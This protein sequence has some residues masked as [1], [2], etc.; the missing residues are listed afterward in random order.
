M[1][2][3]YTFK[4][5]PELK[6]LFKGWNDGA[7]IPF[8]D[9][10][11][12]QLMPIANTEIL[13]FAD[14]VLLNTL[15][16]EVI[17]DRLPEASLVLDSNAQG[18]FIRLNANDDYRLTRAELHLKT[19]EETIETV[20]LGITGGIL[21]AEFFMTKEEIALLKELE[22]IV[23]DNLHSVKKKIDLS[24]YQQEEKNESDLLNAAGNEINAL[25]EEQ[26][27]LSNARVANS[28]KKKPSPEDR[29]KQAEQIEKV[30]EQLVKKDSVQYDR[31]KELSEKLNELIEKLDKNIPES[32]K[33]MTEKQMEETLAKLE[34]EW[35][36]LKAIE[37]LKQLDKA[38]EEKRA[39]SEENIN[40]IQESKEGLEKVLGQEE[41]EKL[42]WNRFDSLKANN[43]QLAKEQ[44]ANENE[45]EQKQEAEEQNKQGEQ[46]QQKEP[47]DKNTDKQQD[48]IKQQMKED[49]DAL[50]QQLSELSTTMMMDAM[51]KNVE[52]IRRLE[53]RS[54][55]ASKKQ[56]EI[57]QKAKVSTDYDQSLL[58]QQKEVSLSARNILDSL[59]VLTVTD[60]M[61]ANVLAENKQLLTEHLKAIENTNDMPYTRLVTNQ[62]YLQFSL[63]DLASI[64]YDILK[65]ESESMQSMMAG[66]KQCNK[67]KSGKG[68]KES[69]SKK[70]KELGEK[71]GKV[72]KDGQGNPEGRQTLSQQELLELIKG[73][74][75]I[76]KQFEQKGG[77]SAGD[78]DVLDQL[79]KQL[80][81]LINQNLDKAINRNKDIEDK[82]ITLEK[83]ENQKKE[84]EEKRKSRESTM[85]YDAIR[86]AIIEDYI[87]QKQTG[88]RIVNLPP[89]KSY[90][91]GKWIKVIQE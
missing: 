16:I 45:S 28:S 84:D 79:N 2:V 42:D 77:K 14:S 3:S 43:E 67:P 57:H 73:Q 50:K 69:L 4:N 6:I 34:K 58:R 19:K 70:Q 11:T 39:A 68:Q 24:N 27:E 15:G 32:E 20:P 21:N 49:S 72:K 51:Q 35:A 18:V 83:S 61:L 33:R 56:E 37:E 36:I 40:Q 41:K 89:L 23:F 30:A 22:L 66:N 62:R 87:K 90:Y 63:N 48:D 59:S 17:K 88:S 53:L 64:L 76:I 65:S 7:I 29:K 46:S 9:R 38:L 13:S 31:F 55:K 47:S 5:A 44:N 54:L 75:E 85:D 25:R 1:R 52:L 71:M 12:L 8:R 78:K 10:D 81:D 82:L 74:E 26:K 86:K 91:T 80:D 60:P